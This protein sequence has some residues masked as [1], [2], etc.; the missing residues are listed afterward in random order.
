MIKTGQPIP[1]HERGVIQRWL[2]SEEIKAIGRRLG[3]NGN[4]L[5]NITNKEKLNVT[6]TF[7]KAVLEVYQ[8]AIERARKAKKQAE[9]DL[10]Q[11]STL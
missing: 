8:T 6:D 11:V 7:F 5:Y 9:I 10:A 2:T 4:S 1:S 3:L